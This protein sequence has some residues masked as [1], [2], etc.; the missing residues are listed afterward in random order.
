MFTQQANPA[1]SLVAVSQEDAK[2]TAT[3]T[4]PPV[5][6]EAQAPEA[7]PADREPSDQTADSRPSREYANGVQEWAEEVS[8]EVAAQTPSQQ[9]EAAAENQQIQVDY[10]ETAEQHTADHDVNGQSHS[11]VPD[12]SSVNESSQTAGVVP[13]LAS[14]NDF[15]LSELSDVP[16]SSRLSSVSQHLLQ[17]S[18]TKEWADWVLT[19]NPVGAQ[20]FASYAHGLVLTR[21]ERLRAFM[22]RA[23]NANFT[24]NLISLGPPQP[25]VPHAFE[26]ALRFLYSD[27]VLSSDSL[28]PKSQSQVLDPVRSNLLTYI[29]SYWVSGIELGLEPVVARSSKLFEDFLDWDVAE[30]AMKEAYEL[31]A[32]VTQGLPEQSLLSSYA[33]ATVRMQQAVLRFCVRS[34]D[35]ESYGVQSNVQPTIMRSRLGQLEDSRSRHNP[36]LAAMRFGS[37]PSSADLSPSS[38]QSET[39]PVARSVEDQASSS[40]LLNISFGNLEYFAY[41]LSQS[42]GW[43]GVNVLSQVVSEREARRTKVV[44]NRSVPNKQRMSNSATWDIAGWRE[45][46]DDSQVKRERVGFALPTKQR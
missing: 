6:L 2:R 28:Y 45:F 3:G 30:L 17:L 37:M 33:D 4:D 35:P 39:L 23:H 20:T 29:I 5:D 10:S 41:Q 26:A 9:D 40:I 24:S 32:S 38:T 43:A 14:Q 27:T 44:S 16:N 21:S 8:N 22:G 36:A 18:S 46:I 11:S 34:I 1:E 7:E 15:N 13:C 19:V 12:K 25:V 42:Y 31:E